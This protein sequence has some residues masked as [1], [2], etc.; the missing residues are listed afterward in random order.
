MLNNSGE[1][2]ALINLIEDPDEEIYNSISNRFVG[3]GKTI[4][5]ILKEQLDFTS[6]PMIVKRIEDILFKVSLS[7]LT[8]ALQNWKESTSGSL[9]NP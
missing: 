1:I 2:L 8:D 6:D 7:L 9:Q 4:L 5:P 3:Y